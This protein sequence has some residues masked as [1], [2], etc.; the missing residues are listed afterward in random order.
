MISTL[1]VYHTYDDTTH[2]SNKGKEWIVIV[3]L[4]LLLMGYTPSRRDSNNESDGY[5]SDC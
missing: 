4:L 2:L 5:T 1:I 3:L